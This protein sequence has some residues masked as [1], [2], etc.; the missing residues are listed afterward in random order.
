MGTINVK[1][2]ISLS[3]CCNGRISSG[4][5]NAEMLMNKIEAF[6]S[7]HECGMSCKRVWHP[8]YENVGLGTYR[9]IEYKPKIKSH[10]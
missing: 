7:C 6:A 1:E 3:D 4:Q 9:K 2:E 10:E 8:V 5:T